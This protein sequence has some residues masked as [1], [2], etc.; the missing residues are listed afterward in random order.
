[1]R[2]FY[3]WPGLFSGGCPGV[4]YQGV[5]RAYLCAFGC[6]IGCSIGCSGLEGVLDVE[7]GCVPDSI[8]GVLV[9]GTVIQELLCL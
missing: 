7:H 6:F 9:L 3:Y 5:L 2:V 4:F 1:M 8:G